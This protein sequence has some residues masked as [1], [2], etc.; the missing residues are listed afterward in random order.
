MCHGS[1]SP[2]THDLNNAARR[3]ELDEE[4]G[5]ERKPKKIKRK[6]LLSS[7]SEENGMG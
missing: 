7:C 5:R 4:N 3:E 1:D 6:G 2:R